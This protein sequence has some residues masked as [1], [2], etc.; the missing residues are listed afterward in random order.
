ME[1][2][3]GQAVAGHHRTLVRRLLLPAGAVLMAIAFPVNL[4]ALGNSL[5][6]WLGISPW[7]LFFYV[8]LPPLLLDAA[9]RIDWF[10]FRKVSTTKQAQATGHSETPEE[11]CLVFTKQPGPL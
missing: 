11:L 1:L 9:V 10:M 2:P 8:F 4:G 6:I 5:A 3:V 7:Q